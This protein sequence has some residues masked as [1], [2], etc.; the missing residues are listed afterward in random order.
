MSD[1]SFVVTGGDCKTG[2]W[3]GSKP[4]SLLMMPCLLS[5]LCSIFKIRRN[6]DPTPGFSNTP[7]F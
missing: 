2:N 5:L 6:I 7:G 3:R 4:L 1:A